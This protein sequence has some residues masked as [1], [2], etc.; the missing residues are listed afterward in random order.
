MFPGFLA[1]IASVV[2]FYVGFVSIR[3]FEGGV[4]GTLNI[5]LFIFSVL[6]FVIVKRDT[7]D[8]GKMNISTIQFITSRIKP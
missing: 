8:A 7:R 3:G 1:L 6:Y 4:Y 5:I 2:L